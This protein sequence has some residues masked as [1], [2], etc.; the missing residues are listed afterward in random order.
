ML[1]GLL[2][3]GCSD[4]TNAPTPTTNTASAG[5]SPLT[6]PVDYLGTVGNAKLKAEKTVDLASINRAIQMFQVDKGRFPKDLNELVTEKFL[7]K[8]PD[9]PYGMKFVYDANIGTVKAVKA[10]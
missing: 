9:A 8:L 4:S 7:P 6:A 1:A 5:S 2:L 10:Q 3:V